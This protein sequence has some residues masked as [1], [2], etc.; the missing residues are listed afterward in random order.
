MPEYDE[1][2]G[3]D[4]QQVL[5]L[6]PATDGLALPVL[7]FSQG[8]EPQVTFFNCGLVERPDGLWLLARRSRNEPRV[9][10]GFNDVVAFILDPL[11]YEPQHGVALKMQTAFPGQEHFED[12]RAV[13][14]DGKTFI[15][16]CN[17]IVTH[18]GARWT[19]AHQTVNV[20]EEVNN[21]EWKTARRFDPVYGNNGPGIG[22]TRAWKRT[23]R[24]SCAPI[25]CT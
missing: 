2:T 11:T 24:P 5:A 25:R 6:G 1:R 10:I 13:F 7:R 19:G 9:K 12:P 15:F 14:H 22:G 17:F 21:K 23:G 16:C 20:V 8:Q 4:R 18:G 3:H